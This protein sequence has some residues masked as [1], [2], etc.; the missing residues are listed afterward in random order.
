MRHTRQEVVRRTKSEFQRLD[1]LVEGLRPTDWKRLVPRPETKDAWTVK[2]ALAH[3]VHWKE[4]TA[5]VIRGERRPPELRGLEVTQINHLIYERWRDQ[6]PAKV[7]NWHRQV[8]D[9]VLRTL[10]QTPAE[11]FSRRD[12]TPYWPGDLDGHSAEHRVKDLEAALR[13]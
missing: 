12:R 8:Q 13:R 6:P 2:D 9:D 3:I 11:W 7:V 4:H 1:R 5:R 10:A